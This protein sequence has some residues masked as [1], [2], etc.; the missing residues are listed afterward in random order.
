[1]SMIISSEGPQAPLH[2][3]IYRKTDGSG[4]YLIPHCVFCVS[5]AAEASTFG[6]VI[7]FGAAYVC[8]P[9]IEKRKDGPNSNL[10]VAVT[11]GDLSGVAN[12]NSM[13]TGS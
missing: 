2:A 9:C 12:T 8:G 4:Y 13:V 7:Q 5:R 1:M 11:S 6:K 10:S 3:M